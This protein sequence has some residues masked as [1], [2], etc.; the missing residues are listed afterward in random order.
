[1]SLYDCHGADGD[2]TPAIN[3]EAAFH[4]WHGSEDILFDGCTYRGDAG[5]GIAV[6][7]N[8]QK[9]VKNIIFRRCDI[10]MTGGQTALTATHQTP[11]DL[12]YRIGLTVEDSKI[13][14]A[15]GNCANLSNVDGTFLRNDMRGYNLCSALNGGT[16]ALFEDCEQLASND[17]SGTPI[18]HALRVEAGNSV[19]VTRGALRAKGKSPMPYIGNPALITLSPAPNAPILEP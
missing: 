2:N 4:P 3:T 17:P 9:A 12:P 14:S 13:H 11:D 10:H 7:A 5:S 8:G 18:A 1:V 15:L 19:T 6:I 16:V